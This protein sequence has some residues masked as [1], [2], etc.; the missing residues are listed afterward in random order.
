MSNSQKFTGKI[1]VGEW[2][3]EEENNKLTLGD[4]K[5]PDLGL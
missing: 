1:E 4:F 3:R 2:T 5:K